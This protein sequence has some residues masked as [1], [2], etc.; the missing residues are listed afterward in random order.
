[1]HLTAL[2]KGT[3][4]TARAKGMQLSA[5]DIASRWWPRVE[6]RLRPL[7]CSLGV[8]LSALSLCSLTDE[9][10]DQSVVACYL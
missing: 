2:A 9:H 6:S 4:L 7:S 5:R 8:V 3:L 10:F 1:M